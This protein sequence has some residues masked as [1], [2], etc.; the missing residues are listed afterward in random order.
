[1]SLLTDKPAALAVFETLFYWWEG[2]H[3]GGVLLGM[4]LERRPR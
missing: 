3:W 2:G 1:M 4:T